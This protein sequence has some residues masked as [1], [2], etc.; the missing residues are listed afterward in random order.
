[1][2]REGT[3]GIRVTLVVA[4]VRGTTTL[5]DFPGTTEEEESSRR[6]AG[7]ILLSGLVAIS[8]M[9]VR[10]IGSSARLETTG[11]GKLEG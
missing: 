1:M 11:N 4:L 3:L 8:V 2:E 10:V 6:R 9:R 5:K 7:K